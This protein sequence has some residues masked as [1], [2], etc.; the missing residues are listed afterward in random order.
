MSHATERKIR[1]QAVTPLL[2]LILTTDDPLYPVTS[3]WV[4]MNHRILS[5]LVIALLALSCAPDRANE[6]VSGRSARDLV[7]LQLRAQRPVDEIST[8]FEYECASFVHGC[9]LVWRSRSSRRRTEALVAQ[10]R[11]DKPSLL[12][13]IKAVQISSAVAPH[14]K[15]V[16]ELLVQTGIFDSGRG[17]DL[18]AAICQDMLEENVD[19]AYIYGVEDHRPQAID[20][21]DIRVPTQAWQP[22]LATCQ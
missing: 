19:S 5:A 16:P 9:P 14:I 11:Q 20:E 17:M 8:V 22:V 18:G 2:G 7:E 21:S 6:I 3:G 10:L 1:E 4:S 12:R 13:Y 15:V